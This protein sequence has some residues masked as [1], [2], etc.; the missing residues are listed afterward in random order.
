M[1]VYTQALFCD[2]ATQFYLLHAFSTDPTQG[3][4]GS[5]LLAQKRRLAEE[6]LQTLKHTIMTQLVPSYHTY[7]TLAMLGNPVKA[8]ETLLAQEY[9][10]LVVVRATGLGR[11]TLFGSVATD[12]IRFDIT[13]VLVVPGWSPVRAIKRL[14]LAIDYK[15][16]N[17]AESFSFLTELA[18][19]KEARLL[20]LNIEVTRQTDRLASDLSRQYVLRAFKNLQK[21]T[22]SVHDEDIQQGINAYLDRYPVDLFVMLPHHKRV[23]CVLLNKSETH[24]LAYHPRVTLMTLYD[25]PTPGEK[26]S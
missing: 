26:N 7:Q 16:V 21:Q 13:N 22:F 1:S 11:T 17:N 4:T 15:S 14:V 20:L 10:D 12:I 3:F 8:I 23:F 24:H 5:F 2:T 25:A 18:R 9:F 6:S 19:R